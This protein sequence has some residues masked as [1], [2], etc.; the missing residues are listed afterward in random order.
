MILKIYGVLWL[1]LIM[2]MPP[3]YG[4]G[5]FT[6]TVAVTYGFIAFGMVFMGMIGVLPILA[7]HPS[8]VKSSPKQ[9]KAVAAPEPSPRGSRGQAV[10]A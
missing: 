5:V 1:A 4:A 3:L 10:H 6:L 9:T 7:T 8:H 2:S